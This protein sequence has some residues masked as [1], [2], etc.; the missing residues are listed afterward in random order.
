MV[1]I[2]GG[3][4]PGEATLFKEVPIWVFQGARDTAVLPEC[5]R[6]MVESL[7][8]ISGRVRYTEY[9]DLGH[10]CWDTAYATPELY[11]W[12]L[13]QVRGKPQQVPAPAEP[14]PPAK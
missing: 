3:G 9:P 1:P 7:R 11:D 10:N 4:D 6:V 8:R 12:L 14:A 13:Q 2:C 5:S